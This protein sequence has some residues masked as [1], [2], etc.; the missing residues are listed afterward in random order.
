[1]IT[2]LPFPD[3]KQTARVLDSRRLGKQRVEAYQLINGGWPNHPAAK[4]W[5]GYRPALM[6][7]ALDIIAEWKRRGYQDSLEE[8]ILNIEC[9]EEIIMPPWLG[10]EQLHQSHRS[11]LIRK[12]PE[13]Y[14]NKLHWDDPSDLP[15]Y[16]PVK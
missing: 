13:Y 8:K 10:I 3:F 14:R 5:R 7:Y 6:L 16:W 12:F 15:Y 11:N 4:M 1:M 2:F 9:T